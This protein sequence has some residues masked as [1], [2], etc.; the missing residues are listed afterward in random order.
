V[1]L[2]LAHPVFD[3]T[4]TLTVSDVIGNDDTVSTLVVAACDSLESLLAG[5]VPDLELDSLAINIDGSDFLKKL[6]NQ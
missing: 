5:S 3:G 4:E 1:F 6:I 2:Y